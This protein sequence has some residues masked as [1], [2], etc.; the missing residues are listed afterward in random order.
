MARRADRPGAAPAAQDKRAVQGPRVA[1]WPFGLALAGA[2][3]VAPPSAVLAGVLLAPALLALLADRAPGRPV[4]RCVLL[5]ALA[6]AIPALFALWRAGHGMAMAVALLGETTPVLRAW[7]AAGLGWLVAEL[8][9]PLA[10]VAM[11]ALAARAAQRLR[12]A[13]SEAEREWSPDD[14]SPAA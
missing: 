4:G 12:A 11:E 6:G 7:G 5:F 8:A 2:A 10:R 3:A 9:P 13:R 1:L 14:A